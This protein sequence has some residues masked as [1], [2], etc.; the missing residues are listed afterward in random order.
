M[1]FLEKDKLVLARLTFVVSCALNMSSTMSDRSVCNSFKNRN[2]KEKIENSSY[3][4]YYSVA[5]VY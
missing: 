2:S 3:H 5:K 1:V 4:F